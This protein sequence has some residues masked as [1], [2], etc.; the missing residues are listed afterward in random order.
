M[1]PSE[2][3]VLLID[4]SLDK[5]E[6]LSRMVEAG[7]G[8]VVDT[9]SDMQSALQ[10][11]QE[12]PT[13]GINVALIDGNL[14]AYGKYGQE[15]AQ[16]FQVGYRD[17]LLHRADV[18]EGVGAVA[19][20]CSIDQTSIVGS[21]C[22]ENLGAS[23]TQELESHWARIIEPHPA[24]PYYPSPDTLDR[25]SFDDFDIE[26]TFSILF[27]DHTSPTINYF[28]LTHA[29]V[30]SDTGKLEIINDKRE[31][32]FNLRLKEL[33]KFINMWQRQNKTTVEYTESRTVVVNL[34]HDSRIY[35]VAHS[36]MGQFD[37]D[38]LVQFGNSDSIDKNALSEF[39]PAFLSKLGIDKVVKKPEDSYI[40]GQLEF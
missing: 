7:G 27:D 29:R 9:A 40:Q 14:T 35:V 30:H 28:D 18:N 34:E 26:D 39:P 1:K 17:G 24:T 12:I 15:G 31:R 13:A 10:K 4:D 16:V 2:A 11:V 33:V 20:A 5:R 32:P 8:I 22:G 25:M 21:V 19:V 36:A 37:S 23:S 3:R 38:R 6:I